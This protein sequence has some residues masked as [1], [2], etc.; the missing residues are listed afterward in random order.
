MVIIRPWNNN[1][2]LLLVWIVK[3]GADDLCQELESSGGL[4]PPP[5]STPRG[6]K[7]HKTAHHP[8]ALERADLVCTHQAHGSEDAAPSRCR[9]CTSGVLLP[10]HVGKKGVASGPCASLT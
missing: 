6:N 7:A 9:H 5:S 4:K 2:Y 3:T 8:I 10:D 1:G